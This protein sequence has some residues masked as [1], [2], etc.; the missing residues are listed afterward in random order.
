MKITHVIHNYYPAKGGP[1]Y[2]LK[3]LSEKLV[4]WH[5]DEVNVL[6]SDSF[7]GPEMPLY[8]KINPAKEIINGVSVER[9]QFTRWHYNLLDLSNKLYKRVY[10]KALPNAL[11]KKRWGMDSI[12]LDQA[13]SKS[14]ANVIMAS[15]INYN[16][17]DYP[18]W[19][20]YTA[21][22]KPF[23]VYGSLHM[24]VKWKQESPV[25]RRALACDCYIANTAYERNRLISEYGLDESKIVS[26]GTGIEA[27]AYACRDNEIEQF[28]AKHHISKNQKIIGYIGRLSEGKGTPLLLN[29]FEKIAT[30]FSNTILLLAGSKTAYSATIAAGHRQNSRIII[31]EDFDEA[32]K[33]ILFNAIDIFV[34]AS[35][36]ES[37]GVVFLEAWSCKKPVI[38]VDSEALNCI[39][40]QGQDG[41]LFERDNADALAASI[42]ALLLDE[43]RCNKMGN[44]GYQKILARYSWAQIVSHYRKAYERGIENFEILKRRQNL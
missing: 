16:F 33:R 8:K 3:H 20:M 27:Q 38:G 43:E 14:Q 37:F 40:D 28:K 31:L 24:H 41:V 18:F 35:K 34:L 7:Y 21:K 2:T 36:G 6:T 22:P 29:A 42:R 9:F 39:I 1:Q 13:L 32:D 10:K 12:S 17:C 15:T 30:E 23:V 44:T 5:G 11:L 19:R 26:I 25:I 4:E